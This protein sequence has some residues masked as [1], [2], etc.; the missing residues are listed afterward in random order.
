MGTINYTITS[1]NLPIVVQLFSLNGIV[2]TNFHNSFGSYSFNNV[3]YQNGMYVKFI[4]VDHPFDCYAIEP[5]YYCSDCPEGYESVGTKCI[6]YDEIDPTFTQPFS[7]VY[8]P[9]S[10]YTSKGTLIFDT[11]NYNGTGVYTT[12]TPAMNS[13]WNNTIGE[14]NGGAMNRCAIWAST[15]YEHQDIGVS[16]CVDI[17]TEKT[18]YIGVG[19]DNYV[20]IKLNGVYILQQDVTA[21]KA[22]L[23]STAN[24]VTFQYWYIYPVELP[25]GRSIIEVYGHNVVDVA[26]VGIQIYDATKT[27]L[28]NAHSNYDLINQIKFS[29]E[30]LVGHDLLYEYTAAHGYHGYSCPAGYALTCDFPPKCMK[31]TE[32]DCG[33]LP[34]STTTSTT[35]S[36][37]T[38][39]TSSTTTTTTTVVGGYKTVFVHYNKL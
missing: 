17:S 18:Y 24:G 10:D 2:T 13:Y 15:L 33:T 31:R 5:I 30:S 1:G 26:A 14:G 6:Y 23:G 37:T 34:P 11:W 7:V 36:T 28:I 21:L 9:Y 35:S 39:S 19:C 20:K 3:T 12:I 16:F 38:T 32:V 4:E 25:V 29:S 27:S 22:M 8:M